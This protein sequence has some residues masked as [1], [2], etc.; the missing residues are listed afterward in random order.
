MKCFAEKAKIL[1]LDLWGIPSAE[2]SLEVCTGSTSVQH[3]P[4]VRVYP[5]QVWVGFI[6]VYKYL[7]GGCREDRAV[8]SVTQ[9]HDKRQWTQN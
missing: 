8:F 9:W 3:I 4:W 2:Q 7:K 6:K 1:A 5:Q